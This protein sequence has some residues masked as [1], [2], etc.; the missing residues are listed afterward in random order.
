MNAVLN[1]ILTIRSYG[2]FVKRYANCMPGAE[3][4]LNEKLSGKRLI[5]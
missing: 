3:K 5:R 4:A 1:L 2:V